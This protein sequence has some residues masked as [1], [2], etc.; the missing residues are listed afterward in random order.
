MVDTFLKQLQPLIHRVIADENFEDIEN[1]FQHFSASCF[2]KGC[3]DDS[4]LDMDN[5]LD[6]YFPN[7]AALMQTNINENTGELVLNDDIVNMEQC[8]Q[9]NC[10]NHEAMITDGSITCAQRETQNIPALRTEFSCE[11]NPDSGL[12]QTLVIIERSRQRPLSTFAKT[13]LG[14]EVS[15][16]I[17]VS[18]ASTDSIAIDT[19]IDEEASSNL[20]T[21]YD[22]GERTYENSRSMTAPAT[23]SGGASGRRSSAAA[24]N[25]SKQAAQ[26]KNY[27]TPERYRD[28]VSPTL[29]NSP[30]STDPVAETSE[31]GEYTEEETSLIGNLRDAIS[32]TI[33]DIGDAAKRAVSPRAPAQVPKASGVTSRLGETTTEGSNNGASTDD[34]FSNDFRESIAAVQPG[35][36]PEGFDG[37]QESAIVS[38]GGAAT[39][40]RGLASSSGTGRS[41]ASAGA[42]A[43]NTGYISVGSDL[44][45]SITLTAGELEVLDEARIRELNIPMTEPFV[46]MVKIDGR[47]VPVKVRQIAQGD[48]FVLRPLIDETNQEVE[49]E[50]RKAP[51]F[52]SYFN[53]PVMRVRSLDNILDG[54]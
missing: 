2:G 33:S 31:E 19:G 48:S 21:P 25:S 14:Q 52:A 9:L 23:T 27:N 26:T 28:T 11:T 8:K 46:I 47:D 44:L 49:D 3:E 36:A 1:S 22:R 41:V 51:V 53:S 12:C 50:L 32:S 39:A 30:I 35:D 17:T 54:Q 34:T 24:K 5:F 43:E 38:S 15:Q 45:Q 18:A 7:G 42:G 6:K 4:C 29:D 10:T 16:A 40:G 20:E 13:I 37:M